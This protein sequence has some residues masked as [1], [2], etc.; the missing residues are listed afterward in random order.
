MAVD[1][2]VKAGTWPGPLVVD[3]PSLVGQAQD[4]LAVGT[5]ATFRMRPFNLDP[6]VVTGTCVILGATTVGC[7]WGASDLSG[8]DGLYELEVEVEWVSGRREVFPAEQDHPYLL[9]FIEPT[10]AV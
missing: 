2:V 9:I 3:L 7:P 6:A 10:I 4:L 8:L 5:T 1:Y